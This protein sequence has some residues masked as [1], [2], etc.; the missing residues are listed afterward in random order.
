VSKRAPKN[1]TSLD[2]EQFRR[3]V[4]QGSIEPLY[5]FVGEEDYLHQQALG[6]LFATVDPAAREFNTATV[7]IGGDLVSASGVCRKATAADAIDIANMLPMMAERSIVVIR[8]F[9]KIKEDELDLVLDYLKRP[10]LR[11]TVVF[12]APSLDQRR[13]ISSALLK[14][15]RLVRMDHPGEKHIEDWARHYL[16]ARGSRIDGAALGNLIGLIG[17]SM[18]RLAREMDKLIVYAGR[19]PIDKQAVEHLVPRVREHSNWELWTAIQ[20]RNRKQAIRLVRRLVED[21]QEPIGIIGALASLYRRMLIAKDL[22]ARG[23]PADEIER[24]T[25]QYGGRAGSFNTAVG[26]MPREEIVRGIRR[27]AKADNDA[28][29]SIATPDLQVEFLVAELTLPETASWSILD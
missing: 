15:C 5:L 22:R 17:T 18:S 21:G 3:S 4:A 27:I 13:K 19:N 14:T 8:G 6:L 23:A 7:T 9:D 28:K 16:E 20:T 26:R 10:S 12:D 2:Y 11:A 25:G 24:A 1:P 29:N